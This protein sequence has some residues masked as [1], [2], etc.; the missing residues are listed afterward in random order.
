MD[1]GTGSMEAIAPTNF[2]EQLPSPAATP[3]RDEPTPE[4][5]A[6]ELDGQPDQN[7]SEETVFP[8]LPPLTKDDPRI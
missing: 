1:L 6:A 2:D 7:Q 3:E 5:T 8:A 4:V